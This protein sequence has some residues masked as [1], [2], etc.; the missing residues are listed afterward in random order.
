LIIG[1]L[2][3]VIESFHQDIQSLKK[4]NQELKDEVN[5]CNI[6]GYTA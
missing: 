1:K 4:I 3:I 2:F 5:R 6:S